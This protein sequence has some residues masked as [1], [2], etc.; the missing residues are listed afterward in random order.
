[1]LM[2]SYS[3][4]NA[5]WGRFVFVSNTMVRG[6]TPRRPSTLTSAIWFTGSSAQRSPILSPPLTRPGI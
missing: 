2:M 6:E 4:L 1:M 3:T 5:R